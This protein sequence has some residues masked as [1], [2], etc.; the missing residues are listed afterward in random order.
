[1]A[2]EHFSM[3]VVRSDD[4]EMSFGDGSYWVLSMNGMADWVELDYSVSTSDN[5]LSDGS[6]VIGKRVAEKD[7]T[8][9]A[10]Y[11]GRDR[12][13]VRDE[14]ISFFNPKFSFKAHVTYFGRT[15]WCEGE[16]IGFDCPMVMENTPTKITWTLLCPD[17]Y[18]RS[19][20]G[21]E[22][23]LTDSAPMFGFPFVSHF[24]TPLP[25]GSK[26][27]VGF[28]ASKM[29]YDGLNT[30]YNNGDV[31]TYYAIRCECKGAVKNPTFYKDDRFV[32]MVGDYQDG[33]VILIDFRKAPPLVTVN[34]VNQ[35]Q[36]CSRDSNFTGMAM[37][38]GA[39]V[40]QYACDNKENRP[41]MDVQILFNKKYLGM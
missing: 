41:Y 18:L 38:V 23:S 2:H 30:I 1:M 20:S 4:K 31:E 40:F 15:R 32:R 36:A 7:R 13:G 12:K 39:N 19:E 33:D 8:M 3:R 35:I 28:L 10:V 14:V 29:L 27:P 21:N 16:Q 37:Q 25:D 26:K 24:R 9:E 6:S 22:N 5:V 17:P 11:W 34:N